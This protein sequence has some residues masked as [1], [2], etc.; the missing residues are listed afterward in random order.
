[1]FFFPKLV[2]VSFYIFS[3]A[4]S[5]Y[6]KR[7]NENEHVK[8]GKTDENQVEVEKLDS[9][10]HLRVSGYTKNGNGFS[11]SVMST[12]VSYTNN[13]YSKIKD[14]KKDLNKAYSYLNDFYENV[15]PVKDASDAV[16]KS[17]FVVEI[18]GLRLLQTEN[19][20]KRKD[21][22]KILTKKFDITN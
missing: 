7:G 3:L 17:P 18:G 5:D 11:E 21:G 14:L 1:M 16:N 9:K 4:Q 2:I 12:S 19:V 13:D 22:D 20:K 10:P 6:S 8:S 15:N